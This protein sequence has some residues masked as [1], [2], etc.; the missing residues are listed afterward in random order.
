MRIFDATQRCSNNPT[1][2]CRTPTFSQHITHMGTIITIYDTPTRRR[3]I[4]YVSKSSQEHTQHVSALYP[5]LLHSIIITWRHNIA[6]SFSNYY[7]QHNHHQS[8]WDCSKE[9]GTF[10][11]FYF[12]FHFHRKFIGVSRS[13]FNHTPTAQVQTCA[14]SFFYSWSLQLIERDWRRV[15]ENG[16]PDGSTVWIHLIHKWLLMGGSNGVDKLED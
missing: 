11:F 4:S 14:C 13:N 16:S 7:I 6:I 5:R 2:T 9:L 8:I 3:F 1:Q 10:L 15:M 12:P